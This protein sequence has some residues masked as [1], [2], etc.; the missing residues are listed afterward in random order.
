MPKSR[1]RPKAVR[2][3]KNQRTRYQ[4]GLGWDPTAA[5]DDPLVQGVLAE[6][7][8]AMPG[9]APPKTVS[10]YLAEAPM[11]YDE[12]AD[13]VLTDRGWESART[14]DPSFPGDAW[15]WPRSIALYEHDA[16]PTMIVRRPTGYEVWGPSRDERQVA[17]RSGV[18]PN[19]ES[20][21]RNIEAI[22]SWRS[23]AA[24]DDED[25]E[26]R[27]A[28]H[29]ASLKAIPCPRCGAEVGVKCISANGV[30]QRWDDAHAA[31]RKAAIG[32]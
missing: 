23:P 9:A 25:Y 7:G 11:A 21:L 24:L 14:F 28:E 6:V 1:K 13:H 27:R 3:Q 4:Q 29:R 18:Y 17:D 32:W 12:S 26:R 16:E 5:L 15:A 31:R 19:L 22:E 8:L 20:L 10:E 2:K 30:R